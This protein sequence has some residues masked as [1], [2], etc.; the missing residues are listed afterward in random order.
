MTAMIWQNI[1]Q[2]VRMSRTETGADGAYALTEETGFHIVEKGYVDIFATIID[3]RGQSLMRMPFITRVPEGAAY[4]DAP[5]RAI[6]HE[7]EPISF[8]FLAVPSR[9]AVLL[10]GERELLASPDMLD[11]DAVTLI[12]DWVTAVS[13]FAA[14]CHGTMPRDALLLEADPHV[15]YEEQAAVSAHHLEILWTSADRPTLFLGH[16]ELPVNADTILPLSERTWLTLPDAAQ[17][18]AV[19]TPGAVMTGSLW[20]SLDRYNTQILLCAE[21]YWKQ[22][23]SRTQGR[24]VEERRRSD[25]DRYAIVGDLTELLGS[26]SSGGRERDATG[27]G[28][29]PLHAAV[30]AIAEKSGAELAKMPAAPYVKDLMEAADAAVSP[31]GIRTRRVQLPP[32]WEQR[33]GPSFLG[34]MPDEDGRRP[35][36]VVNSGRGAYRLIDPAAGTAAPVSR[37]SAEALGKEGVVF[38]APLARGVK[39]GLAALLQ[40]LR[41]RGRDLWGLAIMGA[42]SALVALM[43]PIAMGELLAE[44]IPRV[45]IP[46]WA[47]A[48][49]ALTVGA[50]STVAFSVVGAF[51]ILRIEARIDETL[52]AA[53]WN[54]LI[55]LPLPFFRRYL[56]GDLADRAN[57]VSLIRQT[58]TGAT[59]SSILSGVFSVF[60]FALLFYYSWELAL[61]AGAAVLV[62]VV[63]TWYFAIHQVR[64]HR[65]A[66]MAQG[67][68]DGLVFQM[69]TG[70]AK[71]RQA[72]AEIRALRRWSKLY[73]EQKR[74]MLSAR[75]WAA[76]QHAFNGLFGPVSQILLL[77]MIWYSLIEGESPTPFA[78]ADFL[79]FH[80]AY[81]QFVGG[82][83]GLTGAWVTV[84]AVLPL[85]ERV[86][87]IIEAEPE[88]F[89][90]GVVLPG[91]SGRIECENV[92]FRYPSSARD[93]V[94]DVSFHIRPGEYVAF[95]GPSGSGKSTLYRLLLG[96]EQPSAGTVLLDGHDLE[97]LDLSSMRKHLGVVLQNGQLTPDTIYKNIASDSTITLEEA[98]EAARAAGMEEDL[99]ALPMGMKT[100]L[101]EGGAGL[102]GGQKQRL[103]VARALARKPRVLLFDEATSMLDNRTQAKI[104]ATL[105]GL[106][107]TRVVVAHRLST[108]VDADRIYVMQQ[109]KIV[110][111]G[112]YQELMDR[113]GVL[114][115]L[116]RRQVI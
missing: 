111:S 98:W 81:G 87:P 97:T 42:L 77:A 18:S 7:G 90:E 53:V 71:L 112:R 30:A 22:T 82:V 72:H 91:V 70:L 64:H 74:E 46:M 67:A 15:P 56:V 89:G 40:V 102:S 32:G 49:V 31:S 27:G 57:G 61:W 92:S 35:V 44:I 83:T 58:L 103:L 85:F 84:I 37:R 5:V 79:S 80:A 16:P 88:N 29:N 106:T 2:R 55:S 114:A 17:I 28:E 107:A 41:G 38:Y 39:S 66:F 78:L 8:G 9:D 116:A 21:I 52:Q 76:G 45:D 51:C 104:R 11:L 33:D 65:A 75:M 36:A 96:F 10:R 113:D 115:E 13:D 23:L 12:D 24:K 6:E 14:Q 100:V 19:H 43:T 4:F 99:E 62:M 69:I 94:H 47:A 101:A 93:T 95:V 68:I 20:P 73:S 50:F 26:G 109:G 25:R 59:G 108:V 3:A 54:R 110:E 34:T 1:A 48:L 86:Q 105:K 60:S 63:A